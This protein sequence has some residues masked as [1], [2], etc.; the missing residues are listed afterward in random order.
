MYRGRISV[1]VPLALKQNP[2][3]M[4]TP[5]ASV[6][7]R[8]STEP[9]NTKAQEFVTSA[10]N[11]AKGQLQSNSDPTAELSIYPFPTF[12]ETYTFNMFFFLNN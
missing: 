11:R 7:A 1:S 2:E 6:R 12:R 8:A 5:K 10:E 4:N 3:R 9:L